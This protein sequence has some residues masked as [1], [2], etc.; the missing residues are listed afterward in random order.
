[1]ATGLKTRPQPQMAATKERPPLDL[2]IIGGGPAGLTAALYAVRSRLKVLLIEKMIL[3]G[4]ATT[5]FSIENYPGFPEGVSG[6]EL[7]DRLQ[8][9]VRRLGLDILWG[10]TI[11]L[12]NKKGRREVQ[13]DNKLLTA[14][15]VI[16]AT[17]TE[18]AKLG[19]PGEDEFRGRGVSYCA[20]CDGPFYKD[21]NIMVIGGGNSAIEEALFLTRYA[22][23]ISVV[24]RR[25]Q[26]RADKILAE[27]ALAEP[28]LYFYWHATMEKISGKQKIEEVVLKDLQSQKKLK[29]PIDGVFIYIG[30]KPNSEIVK[31]VVKMDQKGF[32]Q[33]DENMKTSAAG[34]FAA[35]DVRVKSLR[36]VVTAA[37]DGAIAADSARKY[38]EGTKI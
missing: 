1:M 25:D 15:A 4:Q 7:S 28:K 17:G 19:V 18:A 3:G 38:I 24:H 13:V 10:N 20:T 6:T 11:S 33:T 21:K 22:A 23:K 14:K 8:D 37:A 5:T 27:R 29:V 31:G 2:I 34:I 16:V 26:L 30:S 12:K 35:G 32:I 9:Q 36:Q